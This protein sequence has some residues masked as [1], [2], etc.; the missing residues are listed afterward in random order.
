MSLE[1]WKKIGKQI[2]T[3]YTLHGEYN[4][5]NNVPVET[6]SLWTLYEKLP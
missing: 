1:I 5:D 2:H 4:N 3:Y 6:F